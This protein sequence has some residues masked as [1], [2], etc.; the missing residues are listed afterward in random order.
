ME[1]SVQHPS[2]ARVRQELTVLADQSTRRDL[3]DNPG[4]A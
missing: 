3:S 2:A 4:L 1:H